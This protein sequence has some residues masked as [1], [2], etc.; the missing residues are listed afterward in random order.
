VMVFPMINV[1]Y[2]CI[3]IIITTTLIKLSF[4]KLSSYLVCIFSEI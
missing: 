1:M 3:I 4:K 2:F